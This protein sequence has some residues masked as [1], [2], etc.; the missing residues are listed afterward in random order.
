MFYVTLKN[1]SISTT[2]LFCLQTGNQGLLLFTAIILGGMLLSAF[3]L[4][5][6]DLHFS[7]AGNYDRVI[8]QELL[9]EIAQTQQVDLTA[10]RLKGAYIHPFAC[11]SFDANFQHSRRYYEVG[12]L[13]RD[14]QAALRRTTE[15]Y[16]SKGIQP[17]LPFPNPNLFLILRTH[18]TSALAMQ[19][20]NRRLMPHVPPPMYE[21]DFV[22]ASAG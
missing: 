3:V 19:H 13:S 17:P 11:L 16:M 22:S 9:K 20:R 10:K 5:L 15:K 21:L 12:S 18:R 4:L 2:E 8:V 6:L 14:A 7:E 1:V